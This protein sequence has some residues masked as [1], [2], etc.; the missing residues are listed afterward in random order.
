MVAHK[1]DYVQR[2]CYRTD[3]LT[4]HC[5][6]TTLSVLLLSHPRIFYLEAF[7]ILGRHTASVGSWLPKFRDILSVHSSRVKRG[8]PKMCLTK[9]QP[10][11]RNIQYKRRSPITSR[12]KPEISLNSC[13]LIFTALPC[14]FILSKSFIYQLMHNRVVLKEY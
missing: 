7:D 4:L 13:C 14:T 2:C 6:K 11:L 8:C 1:D 12:R 10:K 3:S 9:Y 5:F